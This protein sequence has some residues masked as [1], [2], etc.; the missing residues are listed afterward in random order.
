MKLK[1]LGRLITV[2]LFLTVLLSGVYFGSTPTAVYAEGGAGSPIPVD[3][4]GADCVGVDP[5]PPDD[6]DLVTTILLMAQVIL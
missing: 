2:V 6:S 3:S 1:E 4:T 5:D